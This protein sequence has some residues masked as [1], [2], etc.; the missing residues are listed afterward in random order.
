[1]ARRS[2][3]PLRHDHVQSDAVVQDPAVLRDIVHLF[4]GTLCLNASAPLRPVWSSVIRSI[5]S[6]AHRRFIDPYCATTQSALAP[7]DGHSAFL[8]RA[9]PA[10]DALCHSIKSA[11][12]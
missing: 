2:A 1:M 8:T 12:M 5:F 4:E 10:R 3:R 7:R 6:D 9:L 11:A